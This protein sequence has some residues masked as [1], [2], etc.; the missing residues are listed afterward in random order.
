[1]SDAGSGTGVILAARRPVREVTH[2][3]TADRFLQAEA[4]RCCLRPQFRDVSNARWQTYA[5][6]GMEGSDG[7]QWLRSLGAIALTAAS[8][9]CTYEQCPCAGSG[10]ES[11]S[12]RR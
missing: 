7:G 9:R 10:E 8:D 1:M 4:G 3:N 5:R 6:Q 12:T 2:G 11:V